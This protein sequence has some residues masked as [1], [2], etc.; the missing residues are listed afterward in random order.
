MTRV[1]LTR[2]EINGLHTLRD[3]WSGYPRDKYC[4]EIIREKLDG[5]LWSEVLLDE[6]LFYVERMED[7]RFIDALRIGYILVD[8]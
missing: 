1:E 7:I 5:V 8:R 6:S 3:L 2:D 4:Q